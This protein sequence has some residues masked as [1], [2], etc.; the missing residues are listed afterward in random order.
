MSLGFSRGTRRAF[1]A[2]FAGVVTL[3]ATSA[4]QTGT[5]R[6]RVTESGTQRGIADAQVSISNTTLGSVTTTSGD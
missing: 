2:A 5:I 6:G 4:A 3:A 1:V